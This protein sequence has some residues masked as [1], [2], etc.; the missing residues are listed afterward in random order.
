MIRNILRSTTAEETWPLNSR[1]SALGLYSNAGATAC[2]S[3]V[4]YKS[5][6]GPEKQVNTPNFG[7]VLSKTAPRESPSNT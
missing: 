2:F 5:S 3:P 4:V 6:L 7:F 1:E